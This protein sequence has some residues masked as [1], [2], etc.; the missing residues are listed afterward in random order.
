MQ[1]SVAR[2]HQLNHDIPDFFTD[3]S[4]NLVSSHSQMITLFPV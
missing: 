2:E 4:I 1:G 3:L